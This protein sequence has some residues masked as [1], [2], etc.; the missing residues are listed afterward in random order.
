MERYQGVYLLFENKKLS[1]VNGRIH[2]A[3]DKSFP[4]EK[5]IVSPDLPSINA[6]QLV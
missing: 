1:C 4:E 6:A 2:C 5:P 3:K